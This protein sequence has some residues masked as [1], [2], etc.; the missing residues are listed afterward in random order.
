MK[1]KV[2]H[3]KVMIAMLVAAAI[4]VA[5]L[6]IYILIYCYHHLTIVCKDISQL[7]ELIK[8]DLS[9][10]QIIDIDAHI[11]DS[12]ECTEI[13]ICARAKEGYTHDDFYV[14]TNR[15]DVYDPDFNDVPPFDIE[16][17]ERYALGLDDIRKYGACFGDIR[18]GLSEV[19]Y[20][21]R[22]YE[23]YTNRETNANLVI[24]TLIP[25]RIR[26]DIPL[27]DA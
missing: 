8:I 20:Q 4:L 6:A 7:E 14:R 15:S 17:L 5:S 27:S 23:I 18:N 13:V 12:D 2:P 16:I 10:V 25:R 1:R 26:I 11:S 22:W 9:N 19:G 3:L 24:S 21:I